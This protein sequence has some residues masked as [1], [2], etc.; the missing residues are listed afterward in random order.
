MV[1]SDVHLREV[2][3]QHAGSAAVMVDTEFMR[4]NTFFPRVALV[5]LCFDGAADGTAWLVDP[6]S[7]TDPAPLARLLCD[8]DVIK[9]LHSPSED[10]EVLQH[11]LGVLPAPLFDTQ[12]AAALLGRGFGLGYRAL[13][14]DICAVDLPKGETRSDWLQRPLRAA[15]CDYAAQDVTWLL[16]VWQTLQQQCVQHGR[17]DW[18]LADGR[19]AS[20]VQSGPA[21]EYYPRIKLAWQLDRRELG[22]LRAVCRWREQTARER[23]KP[24]GWIID[25]RACLRLAQCDAR[26]L[27]ALQSAADLPPPVLRRY[28]RALLDL[29]DAQR[30]A[31]ETDLPRSLPAP[32]DSGQRDWLRK[33]KKQIRGIAR[34]LDVAPEALLS[35]RDCE[36]LLREVRGEIDEPPVHWSGWRAA[37]VIAPLRQALAEAAP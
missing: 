10:L 28:G 22:V 24:R 2:L 14:R 7:L 4:R 30:R 34:E 21:A 35:S 3:S 31:P 26:T 11:W 6:L 25:D 23:D 15:Q 33:L 9:V 37:R 1:E 29:L 18:V 16:Q 5:Q 12:R 32:L 20:A 17:L 19:D 8:P 36:L 27:A 13:V